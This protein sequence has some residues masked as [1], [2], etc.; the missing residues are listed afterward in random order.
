MIRPNWLISPDMGVE[1]VRSPGGT[2][3][4]RERPVVY[5]HDDFASDCSSSIRIIATRDEIFPSPSGHRV[6]RHAKFVPNSLLTCQK[7][8]I[9]FSSRRFAPGFRFRLRKNRLG[10]MPRFQLQSFLRS[11]TNFRGTPPTRVLAVDDH[12]VLERFIASRMLKPPDPVSGFNRGGACVDES[13]IWFRPSITILSCSSPAIA[14]F[15]A[16]GGLIPPRP[17]SNL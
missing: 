8:T 17:R 5:H 1:Y 13:S 15:R 4:I 9:Q 2:S 14:I 7:V 10:S 3:S 12:E 16:R 6:R 11:Q